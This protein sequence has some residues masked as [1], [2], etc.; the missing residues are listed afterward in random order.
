MPL[1]WFLLLSRIR[2]ELSLIIFWGIYL[3]SG[4]GLQP[5][6]KQSKVNDL[7]EIITSWGLD[8]KE[9]LSRDALNQIKD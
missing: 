2:G 3:S 9:I 7:K 5:K 6:T 1:T 4:I 8:T